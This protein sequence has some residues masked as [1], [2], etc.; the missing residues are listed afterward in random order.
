MNRENEKIISR[1]QNL[2]E[3]SRKMLKNWKMK[4]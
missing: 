3:S 4:L 2:K 1:K